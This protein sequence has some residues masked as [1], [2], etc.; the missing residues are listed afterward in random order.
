[1]FK[2]ALKVLLV[3]VVIFSL[4]FTTVSLVILA[5]NFNNLGHFVQ[6]W[7]LID[8]FFLWPPE[9]ETLIEG[10]IHGIVDSL[11]DRYSRYLPP[12]RYQQ[13]RES[14]SGTY[15]GIGIYADFVDDTVIVVSTMP[16]TPGERAGLREN[17]AIIGVNGQNVTGMSIND[18]IDMIRGEAGTEVELTI[19]RGSDNVFTVSIV[20]ERISSPTVF[21]EMLEEHPEIAYLRIA[22][23]TQQTY[24]EF[25]DKM[26]TL[27]ESDPQGLIVDLR[28]NPGGDLESFVNVTG[29]FTPEGPVL[30]QVNRAGEIRS[31]VTS[32]NRFDFPIV[33][34]IN[35]NTAS[36]AEAMTGALQDYGVAFVIGETT[37]GK[38]IVQTIFPL[39]N[40]GGLE[41]TTDQYLTP[42][43][44]NIHDVGIAPD[45]KVSLTSDDL[46][47]KQ[48]EAAIAHLLEEIS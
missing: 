9:R 45:L 6:S 25:A 33:L 47:D 27:L 32:G 34:L 42:L 11:G 12:E 46:T 24:R 7:T 2:K 35:G 43:K 38:G 17:D 15:G 23:F 20:R 44:R 19:R 5:T 3:L 26:N 4:L 30:H 40:G 28:S 29:S 1:M 10:M 21:A 16:D 37:F 8:Q 41:L 48:L 36:A 13:F 22:V 14:F 39:G 18:I 31:I